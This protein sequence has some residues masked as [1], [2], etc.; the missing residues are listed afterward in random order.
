MAAN[1]DLWVVAVDPAWTSVWGARYWQA[2]LQ[3]STKTSITVSRHQA[4]AVVIGGAGLGTEPGDGD[5]VPGGDRRIAD[6][7]LPT[8][9]GRPRSSAR[10]LPRSGS[11]PVRRHRDPAVQEDSGQGH[12]PTR[13]ACPNRTP[14]GPGGPG[15]FGATRQR[16]LTDADATG[17]VDFREADLRDA[18]LREAIADLTTWWPDEDFDPIAAGVRVR[19][20]LENADLRSSNLR[21]A[22]LT[23]I[24]LGGA[25]AN[26]FTEWPDGFDWRQAGVLMGNGPEPF[27]R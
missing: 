18:D 26:A 14:L 10:P 11:Y 19:P 16:R 27:E 2:P 3:Q 8:P 6:R 5:G 22:D 21:G 7:E 17:T 13:P 23:G 25:R 1:A 24:S 12:R 4:A 15:P 20:D 9:P